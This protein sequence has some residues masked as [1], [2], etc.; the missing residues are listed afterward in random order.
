MLKL[1]P[2][3]RNFV[4]TESISSPPPI[5][6]ETPG[7]HDAATGVYIKIAAWQS[8]KVEFAFQDGNSVMRIAVSE[9]AARWIS[10]QS[11]NV[12]SHAKRNESRRVGSEDN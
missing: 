7:Y 8:G 2:N 12:A 9:P 1:A 6:I 10:K 11:A 3:K 5:T 4:T